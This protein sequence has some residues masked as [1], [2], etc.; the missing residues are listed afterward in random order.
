M[1]HTDSNSNSGLLFNNNRNTDLFINESDGEL[2][3]E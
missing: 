3:D 2:L 1:T